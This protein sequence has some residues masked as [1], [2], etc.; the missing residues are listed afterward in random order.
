MVE[1]L[2]EHEDLLM[3]LPYLQRIR[4]EG[5]QEGHEEGRQEGRQEGEVE[6]LLR[7]LR[8][9]FGTL[10][11]DTEARIQEA[12]PETLLHWSERVWSAATLDE[13]FAA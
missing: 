7:L 8:I 5:H 6:M 12:D 1:R 4:E 10:P 3:E 11:A 13:V 9:R 2:L